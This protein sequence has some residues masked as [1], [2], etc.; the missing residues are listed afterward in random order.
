MATAYGGSSGLRDRGLLESAV[1]QPQSSFGGAFA[2]DGLFAMARGRTSRRCCRG[3][4]TGSGPCAYPSGGGHHSLAVAVRIQPMTPSK[5]PYP[6]GMK[7]S[8]PGSRP[9]ALITVAATSCERGGRVSVW[10]P[11]S[12]SGTGTPS[13]LPFIASS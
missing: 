2:H 7:K 8:F 1:A 4:R 12:I 3:W 6:P 11:S 5:T 13:G 9:N 10:P